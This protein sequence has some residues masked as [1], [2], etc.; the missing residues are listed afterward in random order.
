VLSAEPAHFDQATGYRIANYRSPTPADV[1]GGTRI[2]ID[3]LDRLLAEPGTLLVDVMPAIGGGFDPASG[4]W[5]LAKAHEH[6]PGSTWLPDVGKGTLQDVLDRYFRSC[7]ADL[8]GGDADRAVVLYCQSDCWMG[9]NA[10]KRAA[11]YGYRR[12]YWY[13]E[14]IDGW[15]D[16]ERPFVL[17]HAVPVALDGGA[18]RCRRGEAKGQP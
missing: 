7:L 16:Y 12:V 4:R 9:W 10:V 2:G 18:A 14:G 13:P 3:E 6:L 1:P 8:T 17:A 15:R 5:R 11:S